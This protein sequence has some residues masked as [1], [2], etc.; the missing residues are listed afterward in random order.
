MNQIYYWVPSTKNHPPPGRKYDVELYSF[1][2]H[3]LKFGWYMVGCYIQ[4]TL[5]PLVSK[6]NYEILA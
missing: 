2:I 3:S 5:D 4:L 6:T 1:R